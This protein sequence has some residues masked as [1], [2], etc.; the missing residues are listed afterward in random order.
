VTTCQDVWLSVLW[1][2]SVHTHTLC[3]VCALIYVYHFPESSSADRRTGEGAVLV[4]L[5]LFQAE[6]RARLQF[7]TNLSYLEY[8]LL[9]NSS[10]VPSGLTSSK[11]PL[12]LIFVYPYL[13]SRSLSPYS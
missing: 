2:D 13:V 8:G 12:S 10:F 6:R 3:V 1:C 11:P 7:Y 4:Y 9:I 5:R